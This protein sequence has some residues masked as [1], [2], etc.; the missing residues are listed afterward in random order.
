M[1]SP[2]TRYD[3]DNTA[4]PSPISPSSPEPS[5]TCVSLDDP[6]LRE[7][8][9]EPESYQDTSPFNPDTYKCTGYKSDEPYEY[10]DGTLGKDARF[11][12]D[13]EG[14]STDQ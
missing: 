9:D 7:K 6:S 13:L 2:E 4:I 5:S 10:F 1:N 12:I 14:G 8:D 11:S 3:T